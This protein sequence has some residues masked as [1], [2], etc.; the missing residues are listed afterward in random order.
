M[1]GTVEDVRSAITAKIKPSKNGYTSWSMFPWISANRSADTIIAVH[2]PYWRSP[3]R[4][5]PRNNNSSKM[6]GSTAK[7]KIFKQSHQPLSSG[8]GILADVCP[9]SLKRASNEVIR[10]LKPNNAIIPIQIAKIIFVAPTLKSM[11][12]AFFAF[13]CIKPLYPKKIP[14]KHN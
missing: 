14:T 3:L 2:F 8:K 9:K 12:H 6:A 13:M 11:R 7:R 5:M 4:I 1:V 10:L